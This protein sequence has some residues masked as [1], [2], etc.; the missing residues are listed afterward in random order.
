MH[1]AHRLW[2]GQGLQ[3]QPRGGNVMRACAMLPAITG[4]IGKAGAG[5]YYLNGSGPRNIDGS[6]VAGAH[7]AREATP[8]I[9]HMDLVDTLEDSQ[10]SRALISWN[11]N[12]AA[13]GPRQASLHA[14]LKRED[15]FTVVVDLF[16]TD[17]ADFADIVLPASSFLEF[18]DLMLPYFH[19]LVSAQ[20]KAEDSPGEVLPNQEIFRRL[21]SEMG[22]VEPE[23]FETDDTII[24]YLLESSGLGIDFETLKQKGWHNP[25]EVAHIAFENHD[26]PTPSGCIEIASEQA[27]KDGHPRTPEPLYDS[28]P[29]AGEFR[30]L[31]PASLWQM[32]NSYG[33]DAIVRRTLGACEVRVSAPD[34]QML[35]MADGDD[36]ELFNETGVLACVVTISEAVPQGVC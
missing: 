31:S 8:S 14:C 19:Y 30:L 35:G 5:I 28:R 9:S 34:A 15:L 11:M 32:N 22:F 21:A 27:Q 1:Q 7:L 29:P 3:R 18:D 13:S 20:V 24:A 26:Y 2:L 6:Y 10:R 23:L 17:T 12:V 16:Q 4:N 36:V 33:N 25:F